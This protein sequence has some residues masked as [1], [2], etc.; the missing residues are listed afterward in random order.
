MNTNGFHDPVNPILAE[1]S[2][3][4]TIDPQRHSAVTQN[5]VVLLVILLNSFSLL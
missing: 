3:F 1:M 5:V 4:E 2:T